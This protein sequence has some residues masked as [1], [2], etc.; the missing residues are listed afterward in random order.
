[1]DGR[2][3]MDGEKVAAG[4]Q[5]GV[6]IAV[7]FGDHEVDI[8]GQPG[9]LP[10]GGHDS[11]PDGKIR[12]EMPVHDVDMDPVRPGRFDGADL[13]PQVAEVGG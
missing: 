11:R 3:H 4:R 13:L 12:N 9:D 1:M 8:E 7:R 6:E 5:K 2:L 10:Q